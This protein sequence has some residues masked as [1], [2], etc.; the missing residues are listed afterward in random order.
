[1]VARD[2][3]PERAAAHGQIRK[4]L[5]RA[6]DDLP[7]AFRIVFVMRDVEEISIED[8]ANLLAIRERP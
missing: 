4:L 3:D 2:R 7:A 5:E 6:I 8:T 1:L